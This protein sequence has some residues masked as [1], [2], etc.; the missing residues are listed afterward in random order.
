M[1]KLPNEQGG[2]I[3]FK[4]WE[5]SNFAPE[6]AAKFPSIKSYIGYGIDDPSIVAR[7][8]ISPKGVEVF[9]DKSGD[10][11]VIHIK[12]IASYSKEYAVY[13]GRIKGEESHGFECKLGEIKKGV[14]N[15]D[16]AL[17]ASD[18]VLRTFRLAVSVTGEY[19]QYHGGTVQDALA[20]VN[21]TL[22]RLNQI[23]EN[24]FA[25]HMELIADNDQVIYADAAT[26][27]YSDWEDG[28]GGFFIPAAWNG[29]L[30]E[31]LSNVIG[32]DS[33]DVGHLF[34]WKDEWDEGNAGC[35]GC[36]C[37]DGKGTG[38]SA[39]ATPGGEI[40]ALLAAHEFGHQLGANH[41]FS[42][43]VRNEGTGAHVEPGSGTTIMGYP[44][45]TSVDV[46]TYT[47]PYYNYFSINQ[48]MTNIAGKSCYTTTNITNSPPEVN[49][50][51]DYVI[52][53][54]TA[55]KLMGA[56]TDAD[57]D[58]LFYTWEQ[59]DPGGSNDT[60]FG[61]EVFHGAMVRSFPPT[62][63][64]YRYIP[65]MSRIIAG[66]LTESSP[67]DGGGD[68]T[69]ETVSNIARDLN[70]ALTVR[71][72]TPDA[73]GQMPQNKTDLMKVTVDDTVG[74]FMVTSQSETVSWT[75]GGSEKVE[76]D[77]AG[78]DSGAINVQEVNI[79][80]TIDNGET[81]I[82]L[83]E[84]VPNDG[85]EFV[86]VP[87]LAQNTMARVVVEAVDNIFLAMN[88]ADISVE[89]KDYVI[90][91]EKDVYAACI[92]T[93]VEMP[94]T[95]K[96]FNSFAGVVDLYV[97][98]APVGMEVSLDKQS[99]SGE[100]E[101]F[102]VTASNLNNSHIGE[103]IIKVTGVYN[104]FAFTRELILNV[105][106][107][108]FESVELLSPTNSTNQFETPHDFEWST[109]ANAQEYIFELSKEADFSNVVLSEKTENN[110]YRLE[111]SLEEGVNYYWRVKPI[112][113]CYEGEYSEV[114][115]FKTLDISKCFNFRKD[116]DEIIPDASSTGLYSELTVDIPNSFILG[117][118]NV[119]VDITHTYLSD[120][121][122]ALIAPSGESIYLSRQ[123]GG[124]GDNYEG[125]IFDDQADT[126]IRD[127][128]A[129]FAGSYIP[130]EP[131]SKF[132]GLDPDGDWSLVIFDS[133]YADI[134]TLISWEMD[135][136]GTYGD[137]D[138]D[139]VEDNVD[140]CIDVANTDQLDTDGDGIGDAC[141]EDD[142]NDGV[143]DE[144]D[145]CPLIPN[146]DNQLDT[147][148]DGI[149]DACD[150]D[151]DNDGVL[152][153]EDN[154]PLIANPDQ[155]DTDGDGKG[156]VCDE[157]DD[158]DGILNASDNC[159]LISNLDQ[160]DTDGDGIGDACD[161]DDDNDGVLDTE[162]NCPLIAN[163]NQLDSDGDGVGDICDEDDDNDGIVD[164]DDNCPLIANPDQL[165]TDG[166]GTGDACDRDDDNDD[167]LDTSDNCP[168]ISNTDQ[169]DTDGDGVGDVCDED[170]DNDGVLDTEDNCPNS[171]LTG[172]IGVDG[173]EV[174][175]MPTDNFEITVTGETCRTANN[176]AV[177]V[178]AKDTSWAYD[179]SIDGSAKT[180][181]TDE[182]EFSNLEAGTHTICITIDEEEYE[183]CFDVTV[184]EPEAL[185]V[186]SSVENT[187]LNLQLS[188][189]EN[190]T[191]TLN[192]ENIRTS[193]S[194]V[195][196]DLKE[197]ENTIS[198]QTDLTC[199]GVY[200][201][202]IVVNKEVKLYPNPV[203]DK[204]FIDLQSLNTKEAFVSIYSMTGK[205]LISSKK[206]EVF[207]GKSSIDVTSLP[208][209]VYV[210]EVISNSE[211]KTFKVVKQ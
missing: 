183:Q 93:T 158:G 148:G 172:L 47:D 27:P 164:E 162:D 207:N 57:S 18:Q 81:F 73:N 142:D 98:E 166:D 113:N 92:N 118:L 79:L 42:V 211:R 130:E 95:Y 138:H 21:V 2:F 41:I 84:K 48:V 201:E 112:N 176:G 46:Q 110:M 137:T 133:F 190:Y 143:L 149:G 69:W 202:T 14:T 76:W 192:G 140:N 5:A 152:D 124:F 51:N 36:V 139:E 188:G 131:L 105:Y 161:E 59:N 125:T 157:D 177:A 3:G 80:M 8:S 91:A 175:V 45:I 127:G 38:W 107:E 106:G 186:N 100:E 155:L 204:L 145:S 60:S 90:T 43:E 136:C 29:E 205:T 34:A 126:S 174:F 86:D 163:S 7:L 108:G 97:S 165:D 54:G 22:T 50:G 9:M 15:A 104:D 111:L 146:L 89:N 128:V 189:G 156:D 170:D 61:P 114:F 160:L 101:S 171:S 25:V 208:Q 151:D 10:D 85:E 119:K 32:D 109:V 115:K 203:H 23:F 134:G 70:F 58:A 167:V 123:N 52:P 181:F 1:V 17:E 94:L 141:D 83:A 88:K 153:I 63:K 33:F 40:F 24:D 184:T 30:G 154:C 121:T 194:R 16:V 132:K 135:I 179:A 197:G 96:S 182:I 13:N 210:V 19:T 44:G 144:F 102:T 168:L 129:P 99:V 53:K 72:R 71:D 116:V 185:D 11:K 67:P 6:L 12:P 169:L 198:V 209:G 200:E 82:T 74:P 75:M 77:V 87:A 26:D 55:Y 20:A 150:E 39:S 196:L 49:A 31:T 35:I 37:D 120:L 173:C 103:H 68:G 65:K 78:T 159:P 64:S 66:E 206:L 199:Q 4:I 28:V 122:L 193:N 195:N 191:I 56:A 187:K 62:E 147:D 180:S 178:K 117:D